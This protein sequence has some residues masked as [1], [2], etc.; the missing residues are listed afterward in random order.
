MDKTKA[1]DIT[2][3]I[4]EFTEGK[5]LL[6]LYTN[7]NEAITFAKKALIKHKKVFD[8]LKDK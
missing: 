5:S 4:K 2:K 6:N 8:A 1:K 3:K 7:R